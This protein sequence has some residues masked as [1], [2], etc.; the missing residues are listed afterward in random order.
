MA[1]QPKAQEFQAG[2]IVRHRT[3]TYRRGVVLE[4]L[5][6]CHN[7][8]HQRS[9]LGCLAARLQGCQYKVTGYKVSV[10]LGKTITALPWE[11][12]LVPP[13]EPKG[14]ALKGPDVGPDGRVRVCH[15]CSDP[16]N[17][18]PEHHPDGRV[19]HVSHHPAETEPTGY[20]YGG[21]TVTGTVILPPENREEGR[22]AMAQIKARFPQ[23]T[24]KP[25][26]FAHGQP[27]RF[28]VFLGPDY[29][30]PAA[31]SDDCWQAWIDAAERN[32]L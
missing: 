3:S 16:N 8:A 25:V 17:P 5:H 10:S 23:A 15:L 22:A 32:K 27:T 7:P 28:G 31:T 1:D 30:E 20:V 24:A 18:S 29:A 6:R 2:D 19:E 14:R 26:S 21:G 4:V 9:P 13:P 11:I 12:E